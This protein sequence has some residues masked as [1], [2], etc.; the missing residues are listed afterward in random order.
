[1]CQNAEYKSIGSFALINYYGYQIMIVQTCTGTRTVRVRYE[2]SFLDNVVFWWSKARYA[3]VIDLMF[4]VAINQPMVVD[5]CEPTEDRR[6]F[7]IDG[8][9]YQNTSTSTRTRTYSYRT[10]IKGTS[11]VS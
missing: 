9:R 3:F 10:S 4:S 6:S 11:S 5:R 8:I 1:M 7:L 2:Y